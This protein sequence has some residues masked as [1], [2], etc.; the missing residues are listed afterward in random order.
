MVKH[1]NWVRLAQGLNHDLPRSRRPLRG[2]SPHFDAVVATDASP[3]QIAQAHPHPKLS[4]LVAPA[5]RTPLR[6]A[7]VDLVTVAAA[8]HWLDH[9]RFYAEVRRVVRPGGVFAGWG[10]K[11]QAVSPQI[12]AVVHRLD[13]EILGPYWLPQVRLVEQGYRTVPFPFEEIDAPTFAL[14]QRW[15]LDHLIGCMSTWSASLRYR[16]VTGRDPIDPIRDDL[17]AA[18]GDPLREREVTWDLCLRVGRV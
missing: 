6:D 18:W 5:E 10:Y 13:T 12:D 17:A 3:Q 16:K 1:G 8:L 11:L 15:D 2:V 4:H 9:D 14:H 7:S